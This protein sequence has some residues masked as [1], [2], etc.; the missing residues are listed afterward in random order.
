M[1]SHTKK[2]TKT[3]TKKRT[4]IQEAKDKLRAKLTAKFKETLKEKLAARDDVWRVRLAAAKLSA[5]GKREAV[6]AR[7]R[8]TKERKTMRFWARKEANRGAGVSQRRWRAN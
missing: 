1:P 2:K 6:S 5:A 4:A 8:A 7:R 3:K